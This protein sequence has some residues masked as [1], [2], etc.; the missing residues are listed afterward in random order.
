MTPAYV[1]DLWPVTGSLERLLTEVPWETHTETRRE[2]FMAPGEPYVYT[3]GSGRGE[4][5]YTSIPMSD[6]VAEIMAAVNA[7]LASD[8]PGWGPM[9]GCFLNRYD[10]GAMHL[11]WHADDFA[12]MR[13]DRAIIS[14]SFGEAR[15][16]WW[17]P[18]GATGVVPPECRQV[19]ASGSMFVMPPGMQ[20]THQHRIPKG[21]RV[22]GPRVSLTFRAF[23]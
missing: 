9:T 5:Q 7:R 17:R 19:L 4:R 8:F 22:M 21:D 6:F 2:C 1:P 14:V 18:F 20:H 3:Y 12:G 23:L 10:D 11:G 13:H 15:D 16:I